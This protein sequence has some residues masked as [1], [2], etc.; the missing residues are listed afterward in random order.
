MLVSVKEL[1]AGLMAVRLYGSPDGCVHVHKKYEHNFSIIL[2]KRE[3]KRK[4]SD[5][6]FLTF[7]FY[8]HRPT[9]RKLR[10]EDMFETWVRIIQKFKFEERMEE[11][12]NER[13]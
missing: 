3:L 4:F 10:A 5:D 9:L 11:R 1:K 8:L 13:K 7:L 12:T 2:I 6:I